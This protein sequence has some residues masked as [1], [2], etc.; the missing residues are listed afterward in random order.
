MLTKIDAPDLVL[1]KLL[2]FQMDKL[3]LYVFIVISSSYCI[4]ET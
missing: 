3:G 1:Q 4:Q 2:K